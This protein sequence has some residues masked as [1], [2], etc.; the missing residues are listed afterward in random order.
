MVDFVKAKEIYQTR[1]R[2]NYVS[3]PR[4][5]KYAVCMHC[6]HIDAES[7]YCEKY[8]HLVDGRFGSCDFYAKRG[9]V[10]NETV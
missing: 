5:R 6:M 3:D 4:S 9:G 7:R 2:I 8:C 1:Q 10:P